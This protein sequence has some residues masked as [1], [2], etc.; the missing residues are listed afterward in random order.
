M[1]RIIYKLAAKNLLHHRSFGL[2]NILGL[3]IGITSALLI[4]MYCLD[5]L[6]F[7]SMHPYAENTYRI[8]Y[9]YS[10]PNG[11]TGSF[12]GGPAGWDN[13]LKENYPSVTHNSG[14]QFFGMPTTIRH[15]PT[16]K[17]IMTEDILWAES[18][19][20]ELVYMDVIEGNKQNILTEINSIVLTESSVE[21]VFGDQDPMNEILTLSHM[22]ATNGEEINLIVTG[23]IADPP[24]NSHL[25]PDFVI[26]HHVLRQF[27]ENPEEFDNYSPELN[28]FSHLLFVCNKPDDIELIREDLQGMIEEVITTNNLDFKFKT[29]VKNVRDLHFDQELDWS[30]NS[31]S[32][33]IRYIYAFI[34]IAI[35]IL[36]VACI[37]YINLSTARSVRRAKEIGLRKTFG[38]GKRYL[39]AQ[40][41]M[42]SLLT[43][44]AAGLLALI[45][46]ILTMPFFNEFTQKDFVIRDLITWKIILTFIITIIITTLV[47]GGF[48]A[49]Y[50]TRF[51]PAIVMRGHFKP[52][53]TSGTFRKILTIVQF[54]ISLFLIISSQVVVKQIS[55]MQDSK[56]NE[57]GDQIVSIRYGGFSGPA[58]IQRYQVYKNELLKN[59][60]IQ[61]V[62]LANHLPRLDYFS[63]INMQYKIPQYDDEPVRW[64]RLNGDYDFPKTFNMELIAGRYFEVGN[65]ADTNSYIVNETAARQLNLGPEE[66]IG[67]SIWE[68]RN[69]NFIGDID[70]SDAYHGTIIGVVKDFPYQSAYH[71]I[72][73]LAITPRPRPIDRIIHVKL[74]EDEMSK[75][76]EYLEETWRQL[77]PEFGFD[78][79]FIDDEFSRMY[80]KEHQIAG[81]TKN[82][83]LLA[84]LLTCFGIFGL[85]S[86]MA[87]QRIKEIGIRKTFGASVGQ[88]IFI[89][90]STFLKLIVIACFIAIPAAMLLLSRYWLQNFSYQA[91]MSID[92]VIF[93]ALLIIII[94]VL[95]M[96]FETYKAAMTNPVESLKY[97]G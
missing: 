72:E 6:S 30:F 46:V 23:V 68:P 19:I 78:Y 79:W 38:S 44:I 91:G 20:Q 14:F 94:T 61:S 51:E 36:G 39:I 64:N 96:A 34:I 2:L 84:I 83:T 3:A 97:E 63:S 82:F 24:A 12:S 37:N 31:K 9:S 27:V 25:Q 29:I 95:T 47:A 57:A 92:V 90:V 66:I 15:K 52:K 77:Y 4:I 58:T 85:S 5:E 43:V 56:L 88:I 41:M 71:E 7:D 17:I 73:P 32:A 67:I 45:F 70:F 87:Q 35:M 16:D 65:T 11:F 33:D 26:N 93:P 55:F 75:Q 86:Y 62:T 49:F 28:Q 81:I 40:L 54:I 74:S 60:Q 8:G 10:S 22:W 21:M 53:S 69:F 59:P 89:L 13:Y 18:N 1:L 42:E 76:I 80:E 48:P 50:M